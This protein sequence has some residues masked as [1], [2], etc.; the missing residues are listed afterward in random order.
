MREQ[1]KKKNKTKNPKAFRTSTLATKEIQREENI[2]KYILS[3]RPHQT[4]M[5][6]LKHWEGDQ[7]SDQG[8]SP[9]HP[10]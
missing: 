2:H 4:H 7:F 10:R 1:T 9:H 8:A 3:F 5:D 6:M